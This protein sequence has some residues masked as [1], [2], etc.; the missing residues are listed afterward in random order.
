MSVKE[1]TLEISVDNHSR[2][3]HKL[4]DLPCEVIPKSSKASYKNGILDIVIKRKEKKSVK[5]GFRINIE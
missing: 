3:Y 4:I 2:K 5:D 1:N